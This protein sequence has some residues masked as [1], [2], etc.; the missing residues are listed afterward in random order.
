MTYEVWSKKS[1]SV[2]GAFESEKAA[3]EAVRDAI[4]LH[5]RAYGEELALIREDRR[6][7]STPVA[8]GA[9]L[10]EQAL[11]PRQAKVNKAAAASR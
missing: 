6:G 7:R 10:V 1:R 4:G 11:Q 5:G 8:E 2:V 3:L 9:A